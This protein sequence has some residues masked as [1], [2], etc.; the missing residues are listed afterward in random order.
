MARFPKIRFPQ[1]MLMGVRVLLNV[2]YSLSELENLVGV[3]QRTLLDW[4]T[5]GLPHRHEAVSHKTWVNGREF[6]Q[7]VDQVRQWNQ[8]FN[9][10]QPGEVYCLKCRKSVMPTETRI[11]DEPGKPRRLTGQCPECGGVAY[12]GVSRNA[13]DGST[14]SRKTL[15]PIAIE[16]STANT[17]VSRENL[18]LMWQYQAECPK[19]HR[20]TSAANTVLR[21]AGT[22]PLFDA[23]NIQPTLPEYVQN[24]ARL[25][26][27]KPL[28]RETQRKITQVGAEFFKWSVDRHR[29]KTKHITRTWISSLVIP[30]SAIRGVVHHSDTATPMD[31]PCGEKNVVSEEAIYQLAR[32]EVPESDLIMR[33][34]RAACCFLFLS[35]MRGGAF[36]TMPILAVD[37]DNLAVCQYP[38]YGVMT[39]LGKKAR[40]YLWDIPLLL[41]HVREWHQY[42]VETKTPLTTP[43]FL[44]LDNRWGQHVRS[45]RETPSQFRESVLN[46]SMERMWCRLSKP[47]QSP[48]AFRRGFASFGLLRCQNLAD[49]KSIS[50]NLMHADMFVTDRYYALLNNDER[51]RRLLAMSNRRAESPASERYDD[52]GKEDHDIERILAKTS[53]DDLRAFG[54]LLTHL[55]GR[56]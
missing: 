23:P 44:P 17:P 11:I 55:A 51:Q 36:A 10:M 2:E 25:D 30:R 43:W 6:A 8:R 18:L 14:P 40:T 49:Y 26:G 7:W 29:Q 33:R 5:M 41:K 50:A 35:G 37:L 56:E 28:S 3:H 20:L 42:L 52:W 32:L 4:T 9:P 12:R 1:R 31:V 45:T 24:G 19:H 22:R 48:H 21:W 53:R 27:N 13:L 46:D 39:K 16:T 34:D 38:E 47:H 54:K 15:S